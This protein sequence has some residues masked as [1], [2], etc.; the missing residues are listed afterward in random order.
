MTPFLTISRVFFFCSIFNRGAVAAQMFES[1][2]R[3]IMHR[4]SSMSNKAS[5]YYEIYSQLPEIEVIIHSRSLGHVLMKNLL[6]LPN[7]KP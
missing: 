2:R 7:S 5:A 1:I 4:K 3:R 6:Y